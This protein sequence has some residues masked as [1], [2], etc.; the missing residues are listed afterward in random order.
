MRSL[1][2]LIQKIRE[3]DYFL[4]N[5][6]WRLK[7]AKLYIRYQ[8]GN[9]LLNIFKDVLTIVG[10]GGLLT[11]IKLDIPFW[12]FGT[13]GLFWVWLCYTLGWLDELFGF[14]KTQNNYQNEEL[15]PFFAQLKITLDRVNE[16]LDKINGQ[17]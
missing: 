11:Q 15:T 16:K 10:I 12:L 7:L 9:T 3:V 13:L 8:R 1:K 2:E 6:P 4:V 5:I 14:Y 17:K